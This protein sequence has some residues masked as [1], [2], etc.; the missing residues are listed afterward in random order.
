MDTVLEELAAL[1]HEQWSHWTR[2][3]LDNLSPENIARWQRQ[4]ETPYR[5]LSEEE[6]EKD[7]IWARKV[8][9]TIERAK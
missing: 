6:K 7:R 5:E 1:E 9:A 3:L 8:L 2:Y 4:I